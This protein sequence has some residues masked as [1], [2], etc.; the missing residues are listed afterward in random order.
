E[1]LRALLPEILRA[2]LPE[3]LR[4]LLPEMLRALLPEMLRALLPEILRALLPEMLFKDSADVSA[5]ARVEAAKN[6]LHAS[7]I[8]PR[9]RRISIPS[10]S[11]L[12][13][14]WRRDAD[15]KLPNV[16]TL[17]FERQLLV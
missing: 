17:I 2:L 14:V 10:L 6:A 3:I 4:A 12:S 13:V 1:M 9:P 16:I 7:V 5:R 11:F 8:S 15:Q